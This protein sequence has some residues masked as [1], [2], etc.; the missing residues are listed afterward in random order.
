M[1]T[2]PRRLLLDAVSAA[3]TKPGGT[4]GGEQC[5]AQRDLVLRQRLGGARGVLVAGG[6]AGGGGH[7]VEAGG[8]LRVGVPLVESGAED[9]CT[10]GRT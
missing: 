8:H 1:R 6:V 10:G 3:A 7:A 4:T 2:D 5:G 9:Q